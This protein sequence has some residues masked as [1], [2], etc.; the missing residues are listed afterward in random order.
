MSGTPR[1]TTHVA[2]HQFADGQ[3]RHAALCQRL[4]LAGPY[5]DPAALVALWAAV[6]PGLTQRAPGH[7]VDPATAPA[8]FGSPGWRR[9]LGRRQPRRAVRRAAVAAMRNGCT[10]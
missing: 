1:S 6:R 8:W 3:A 4:S 10:C 2:G 7:P 5:D 9:P